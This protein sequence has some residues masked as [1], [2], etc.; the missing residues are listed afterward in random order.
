MQGA[1][2]AGVCER[3]TGMA[4]QHRRPLRPSNGGSPVVPLSKLEAVNWRDDR[5]AVGQ[6]V[7]AAD[8]G[9]AML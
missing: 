9:I 6:G 1:A 4:W 8:V 7:E 3:G 5:G 2:A